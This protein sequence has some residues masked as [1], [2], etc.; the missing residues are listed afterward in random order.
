MESIQATTRP[1]AHTPGAQ[2]PSFQQLAARFRPVFQ[3]IAERAAQRENER[4]LAY[5]PVAWLNA[6]RF[7][8][9]RVPL[10]HGGLGGSVE[11]L[12][13]LLIELGEADSNLPQILRAHFGFIERLLAEIDP[14]LHGPWM[15]L[16]AEGVIFGNA[17]TELG[18]G[19]LGEL[20]T[21]LRRDGDAWRLDGVKSL[22]P[23]G[24]A[25]QLLLV[26]ARAGDG[27]GLFA[28]AGDADGLS[29]SAQR[30]LDPTSRFARL[31]LS[32]VTARRVGD[33]AAVR[34]ALDVG[35]V[36]LGA[37]QVGGARRTL[38][39]AS[40][41]AR[42]RTQFGRPIGGFQ[43]VKHKCA[44]MLLRTESAA[45]LAAYGAWVADRPGEDLSTVAP[46]V[47]SFCSEASL[48]CAATNIQVHG[49]IGFTWE[50][51]A[52]L[53]FTRAKTS[54]LLFGSPSQHLL[55]LADALGV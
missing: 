28:V 46:T 34:R 36:L 7:G 35:A 47:K 39:I 43:A 54:E 9:L 14:A 16:A 24:R 32:G 17:T 50:H 18:E 5:E 48:F 19:P 49:G 8:A 22:V 15:R 31:E 40:G 23:F 25:A 51:P 13:D 12:Y 21:T 29:L 27:L 38:E 11:Q 55:R 53:Y 33:E 52:H 44:D 37:E 2:A 26:A 45:S 41:Y 30:P 4:E 10:E 3:R 20:Q 42:T 1:A 6:E